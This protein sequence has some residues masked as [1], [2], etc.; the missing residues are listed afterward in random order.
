MVFY[1]KYIKGE[2]SMI[3]SEEL[4]KGFT[5]GSCAAAGVKAGLEA[6]F[7]NN[8][9]KEIELQSLNSHTI[10]LEILSL[11]KMSNSVRVAVKKYSGDDPDVT[12]NIEICVRVK[13]I[14]HE[15]ENEI[16][17]KELKKGFLDSNIFITG[18]RGV[19]VTTKAGLQTPIGKFAINPGPLQMI[20]GVISDFKNSYDGDID[21]EK[22]HFIIKIFV[23]QGIKKSKLTLNEKLGVIGGISILGSTGIVKP[24]SEESLKSSLYTELKVIRENSNRDWVIFSFGNY[25]ERFCESLGIGKEMVVVISNYIGFMLE[26]AVKLGF[27]KVVLVG[28][29]GKAIKIAGGIFHTHSKVAD[30]R[31]EIMGA[32]AFLYNESSETVKKILHSNTVDEASKYIENREFFNYISEKVSKKS[33]EHIHNN[34]KCETLIFDFTGEVLGHSKEFYTLIK[35]ILNN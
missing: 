11:K 31:L 25:G 2:M 3:A 14:P 17:S 20:R 16:G 13:F 1:I 24:M 29:I 8:Y 19:G 34:L 10:N 22:G 5:T 6:I 30:A 23:P 32:N 35:E 15:I 9:K 12:N 33:H 27:K 26:S 28:H 21:L 4:K 7:Y 18:G